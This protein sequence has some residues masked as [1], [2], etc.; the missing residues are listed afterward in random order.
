MPPTIFTSPL[1]F[2]TTCVVLCVAQIIYVVFGFGSGLIAV[3]SLALLFPE[4][5]DVVVLLLLLNLP[6][7]AGVVAKS[8][9]SVR[10]RGVASLCAGIAIGIPLGT[11][12]L[13]GGEPRLVLALL[14]GFLLLVGIAFTRLRNRRPIRW[15]LWTGPPVGVLSGLLTG[16]FGTGGP[17]LIVY[18]H[19]SGLDK[20]AFRGNLMMIFLLKTIVRVPA[21]LVAGL[22]TVPRLWSSLLA[23]PAVVIGIWIGHR[24]HVRISEDTFRLLVGVLLGLIGLGLLVRTGSLPSH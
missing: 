1:Q 13:K 19:L 5:K 3:G 21:Y 9:R 20:T 11:A 22:V 8:W 17:P 16:L 18:Y 7:E 23:L 12:V 2:A 6:A 4:L 24:I 10:W 14:G 15:P